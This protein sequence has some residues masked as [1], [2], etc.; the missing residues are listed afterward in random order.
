MLLPGGGTQCLR[1]APS[2]GALYPA[3][4]YVGVRA[5]EGVDA[6]VYHFE[7]PSAELACLTL[8]DPTDQLVRICCGQDYAREAAVVVLISAMFQRTTR[9]YGDRGYRYVLLDVGHLTQ[10]LCLA[11]TALGLSIVTTCGFY[12]EEAAQLLGIDGSDEAVVYVAFV[13]RGPD[14]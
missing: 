2:A 10:N 14:R 9:K 7:V 12:D 13:G 8:G 1:A 3:E 5:V 11:C 6:G 4:V